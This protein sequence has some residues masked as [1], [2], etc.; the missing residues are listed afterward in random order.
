MKKPKLA[1]HLIENITSSIIHGVGYRS[2]PK[3][4]QFKKGQSGNPKGRPRKLSAAESV[5]TLNL[6]Q[7]QRMRDVLREPVMVNTSSGKR[8]MWLGEA[9]QHKHKHL[10]LVEGRTNP[11]LQLKREVKEKEHEERQ[12]ITDDQDSWLDY[13]KNFRKIEAAANEKGEPLKGFWPMPENIVFH[14]NAPCKI[15]GA[16]HEQA[17]PYYDLL[18]KLLKL[19]IF[20]VTYDCC[21]FTKEGDPPR[22][23][24]KHIAY[25][26]QAVTVAAE[27]ESK[28]YWD[29]LENEHICSFW[30]T[31][32]AERAK[33]WADIG[34]PMPRRRWLKPMS[35][36]DQK[37]V[38]R[39][40]DPV[41][42]LLME[43]SQRNRRKPKRRKETAA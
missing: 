32:E 19:L 30:R 43:L 26:Q 14:D 11:L 21:Y 40:R 29:M 22:A 31:A 27:R 33:V 36:K 4:H 25:F 42:A 34:W 8:K 24:L 13:I 41:R 37:L 5:N 16:S 9:L 6:P 2:P 17:L 1:P 28:E 12:A 15:R 3:E 38:E 39:N 35:A 20:E 23:D 7:T 18:E 10:A